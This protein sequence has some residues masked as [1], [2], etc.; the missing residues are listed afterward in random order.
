[1]KHKSIIVAE[2]FPFI[3][4]SLVFTLFAAFF[5]VLWLTILLAALTIFIIAFFRNPERHFQDAEKLVISPAD[6]KVI[7]IEEVDAREGMNGR[8]KKIS[9][10]MNVFNV[11]VNRAPVGGTI[12]KISY[13]PGKF[14]SAD[15]DKASSENERND[16]LIR[17]KD[18]HAVWTVQ[19]AGL[20]ARRIVCWARAGDTLAKGERFGMIRFG[21]RVEVFLPAG[22]RVVVLLNDK[23]RAGQ[24]PL[25]Y[26]P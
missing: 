4:L 5:G 20:I 14:V 16:V 25:G 21:S 13:R 11:H 7:R 15:L 26:L 9:I 23:V 22:S 1:M 6:G 10:F 2:G 19:I 24:T 8:F 18:G 3:I 17:T 12:E